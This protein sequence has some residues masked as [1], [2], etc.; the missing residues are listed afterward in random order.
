[1]PKY[2]DDVRCRGNSGKHLLSLS[3]LA[4]PVKLS[5]LADEYGREITRGA[6]MYRATNALA[7]AAR[8]EAP[9]F[10]IRMIGPAIGRVGPNHS[11]AGAVRLGDH[12]I[13]GN[14][15]PVIL[16]ADSIVAVLRFPINIADGKAVRERTT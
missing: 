5:H 13:V 11:S 7:H 10:S 8:H 9:D 2:L 6:V 14:I 15:D 12:G 3:F 4:C 1:M 16:K